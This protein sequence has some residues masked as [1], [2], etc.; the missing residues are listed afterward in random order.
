MDY[1]PYCNSLIKDNVCLNCEIIFTYSR[2]KSAI[3][4]CRNCGKKDMIKPS[5]ID[6]N[7]YQC[8]FCGYFYYVGSDSP[9]SDKH[10]EFL[11]SIELTCEECHGRVIFVESEGQFICQNCGLIKEFPV[12]LNY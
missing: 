7:L 11:K 1:C 10:L 5:L 12:E 8:E 3:K 2:S 6:P 9:H 4:T